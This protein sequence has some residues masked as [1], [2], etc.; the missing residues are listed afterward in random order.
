MLTE[1]LPSNDTHA[2][3]NTD[4]SDVWSTPLRWAQASFI[5][6]GSGVK[7]LIFG[8]SYTHTEHGDIMRLPFENKKSGLKGKGGTK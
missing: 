3:T 7:K 4:G 6:I 8:D 1:P 5:K 2:D